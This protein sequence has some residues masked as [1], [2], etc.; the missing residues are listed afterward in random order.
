[1]LRIR[2]SMEITASQALRIRVLLTLQAALLG[3]IHASVRNIG[4]RWTEKEIV[5]SILHESQ[6]DEAA[7]ESAS[8]IEAELMASF[9]EHHVEVHTICGDAHSLSD[10]EG[11]SQWVYSRWE[12]D[13]E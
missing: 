12:P 7:V 1:M 4:A 9:P 8:C 6:P 13:E 5:V 11:V 3:E 10:G 2:N